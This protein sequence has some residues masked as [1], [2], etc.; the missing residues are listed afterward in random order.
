MSVFQQP[1][2]IQYLWDQSDGIGPRPSEP[3][4]NSGTEWTKYQ[5]DSTI[6][7]LGG[8]HVRAKDD[9]GP[10]THV[11]GIAAGTGNQTVNPP[12]PVGKYKGVAPLASLI[13]VKYNMTALGIRNGVKYISKRAKDLNKPC[14]IKISLSIVR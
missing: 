1:A 2:R 13:I 14:T 10:G 8:T 4:F 7:G 11:A 12:N 6:F 3:D 5:I 9:D